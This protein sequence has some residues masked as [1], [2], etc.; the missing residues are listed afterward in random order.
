L[1]KTLF[2]VSQ[3]NLLYSRK[4]KNTPSTSTSSPPCSHG[5]K[6]GEIA[7]PEIQRPFVWD[8]SKVRDGMDSLYRGFPV[9]YLRG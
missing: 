8:T 3:D 1:T 6:R 2:A 4:P 5:V 7:I 9:G